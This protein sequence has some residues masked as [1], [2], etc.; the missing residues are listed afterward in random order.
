MANKKFLE[1][2][3]LYRKF[4]TELK[5][6]NWQNGIESR[7]LPKPAIHM[8]CF[9]CDSE[10]TFNMSNEYWSESGSAADY[11]NHSVIKLN[12]LCSACGQGTRVFLVY[13]AI[14]K[15]DA[16]YNRYVV[17][18]VGQIPSWDIGMDK[19]LEAMLGD[20]SVYYRRGLV[21][22]SQSY[23]MGAY[24]Y[25][26]RITEDIIDE[27]LDSVVDLLDGDE[28][29]KYSQALAKTKLTKVTQEKIDL[30]KDLLPVSL[31]PDGVNPLAELHTALSE[32]LHAGDDEECLEYADAIKSVLIYL[33]NQIIRKREDSKK[34]T[35]GMRKLLEKKTKA[36]SN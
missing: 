6:P 24:A 1:E 23:G 10:Q 20:H 17:E 32:G 4:K 30:V 12:Y 31:R 28:K 26:R 27:L 36:G 8:H 14:E 29:I 16:E 21:C 18:K 34:F 9:I 33:V 15:L 35:S 19:N 25:F 11:P 22:E 13:F 5:Y 3:P 2:S 7:N